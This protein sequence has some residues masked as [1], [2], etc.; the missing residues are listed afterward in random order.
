MQQVFSS[1]SADPIGR[2]HLRIMKSPRQNAGAS[3]I[4]SAGH[5]EKSK[6]FTGNKKAL[7]SAC[8]PHLGTIKNSTRRAP[9]STEKM[10]T[11]HNSCSARSSAQ[12]KLASLPPSPFSPLNVLAGRASRPALQSRIASSSGLM[13]MGPASFTL[14]GW[15]GVTEKSVEEL[16]QLVGCPEPE[17]ADAAPFPEFRHDR[18]LVDSVVADPV[19]RDSDKI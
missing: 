6:A 1:C 19:R 16:R 3:G 7:V 15:P 14:F 11:L 4:S 10:V 12:A 8:R 2:E 13:R 5:H 17:E 18:Q 9:D